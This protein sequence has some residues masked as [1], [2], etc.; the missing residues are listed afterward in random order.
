[1]LKTRIETLSDSLF[2]IIMTFLMMQIKLPAVSER[3]FT[4]DEVWHIIRAQTPIFLSYILTFA[5]L[6]NFWFSHHAL[7]SL[8][9]KNI[10]RKLALINILFLFFISLLPFSTGLLG[11]FHY[12]NL[13]VII[14]CV[15]MLIISILLWAMKDYVIHSKFIENSD[16]T[17]E[18]LRYNTLRIVISAFSTVLGIVT[19]FWSTYFAII[20]P[21][22]IVAAATLWALDALLRRHLY[23]LPPATLIFFEHV[24]GFACLLP[25]AWTGLMRVR[26]SRGDVRDLLIVSVLSGILGTLLFTMALAQVHFISLSVVLLLQKLQPIFAIS[27]GIVLVGESIRPRSLGYIALALVAGYFVTFP[28]GVAV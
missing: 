4:N 23:G 14:Y 26:L 19:S 25:F 12:S 21:L 1:M 20:I 24:L 16:M 6:T 11:I 10:N 15:H 8:F 18:D 5:I 7:I 2:A 17:P 9:A 27:A 28:Q 13:V 22:L 3:I